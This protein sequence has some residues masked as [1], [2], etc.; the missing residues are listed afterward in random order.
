MDTT[1][2]DLPELFAQ[3]GLPDTPH[4]I[5]AFIRHHQP[6]DG[7]TLLPDAPFWSP[8]QAALIRQMFSQDSDWALV[9]DD[10]NLRLRAPT[11]AADLPQ[12]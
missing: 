10:L 5:N 4:Q 6:L 1:R 12:A 7:A 11:P 2:H 3:L 9:V 8:A